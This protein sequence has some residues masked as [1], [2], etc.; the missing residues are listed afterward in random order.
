MTRHDTLSMITAMILACLGMARSRSQDWIGGPKRGWLRIQP[1]NRGDPREASQ[2]A[3]S[4]KHVVGI[5]GRKRPITPSAKL[6]A[7]KVT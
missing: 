7:A 2:T 6:M 3:A 4:M 1:A 5:T